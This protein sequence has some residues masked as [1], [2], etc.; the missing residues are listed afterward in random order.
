MKRIFRSGLL[1][2]ILSLTLYG[3][4]VLQGPYGAFWRNTTAI[5]TATLT[6]NQVVGILVG[7]PVA[8]AN[9]TT[10]TATQMCN[11]FLTLR[12]NTNT[13]AS[14]FKVDWYIKN[15]SG[16]ANTITVV[17]GTGVTLSGTGTATQNNMRHLVWQPTNCTAGSEAWTVFSL[18]TAAF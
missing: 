2:V 8:A 7:T 10:P 5:G 4:Q 12:S 17:A 6:I 11:A 15:T 1:A 18:E 13:Y 16:G 3:Q 9:Y 14:T